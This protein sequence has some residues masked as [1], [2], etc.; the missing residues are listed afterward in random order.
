[1]T[2]V[3]IC[4]DYRFGDNSYSSMEDVFMSLP[5]ASR[6]CPRHYFRVASVHL[7]VVV[8]S[9]ISDLNLLYTLRNFRHFYQRCILGQ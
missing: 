9:I 6:W 4:T 5:F 7:S 2:S 8:F 1:M 3:L